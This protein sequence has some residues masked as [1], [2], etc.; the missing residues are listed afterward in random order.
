MA[1]EKTPE[2]EYRLV[3]IK[4]GKEW[5]EAKVAD[6]KAGD[7]FRMWEPD[8]TIVRANN[9]YVFTARTDA[10]EVEY[11]GSTVWGIDVE[12]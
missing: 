4:D 7:K 8:G 3:K 12:E 1:K 11:E 6:L 10:E 9:K 2:I 5:K